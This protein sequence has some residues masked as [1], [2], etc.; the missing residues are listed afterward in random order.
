MDEYTDGMSDCTEKIIRNVGESKF[1]PGNEKIWL[2][3]SNMIIEIN[4]G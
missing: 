2:S 4:L 1:G 3:R